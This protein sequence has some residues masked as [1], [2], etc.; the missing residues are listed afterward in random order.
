MNGDL[1][2]CGLISVEGDLQINGG[3][4]IPGGLIVKGTTEVK[5]ANGTASVFY[6]SEMI[7]QAASSA[8][9]NFQRLSWR[10]IPSL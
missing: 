10:E 7:S 5:P 6:S 8:G 4:W 2:C 9:G 1:T 3:A